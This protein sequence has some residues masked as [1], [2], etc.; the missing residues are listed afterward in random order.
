ILKPDRSYTPLDPVKRETQY[1]WIQFQTFGEWSAI[2]EEEAGPGGARL[3]PYDEVIPT[4][5]LRQ[6][7]V[8]HFTLVVPQFCKLTFPTKTY[9]NIKRLID[10]NKQH[11]PSVMWQQQTIFQE[12]LHDLNGEQQYRATSSSIALAEKAAQLI[13]ERYRE[14]MHYREI[15]ESLNFH[16][17]YI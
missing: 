15:G 9:R 6:R 17:T 3:Y 11:K 7:Q 10:L 5:E 4:K 1:Y 14:P 12:V 8:Q 13:R 16:P 2:T